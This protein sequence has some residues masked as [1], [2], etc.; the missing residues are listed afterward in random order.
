MN[1]NATMRA[2]EY[3]HL[4]VINV[5]WKFRA[6]KEASDNLISDRS[7]DVPTS[8]RPG[9]FDEN[10]KNRWRICSRIA[11]CLTNVITAYKKLN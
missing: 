9:E 1:A 11:D 4:R 8:E 2:T 6:R 3:S 5:K 10:W 7:I